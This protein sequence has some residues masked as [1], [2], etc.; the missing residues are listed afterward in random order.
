MKKSI[1]GIILVAMVLTILGGCGQSSTP[2]TSQTTAISST[3]A[4]N[5]ASGTSAS[6]STSSSTSADATAATT[7]QTTASTADSSAVTADDQDGD[8]IPDLVEKTYGT[9]P[10]TADTD[11][12]GTNDVNDQTPVYTDNLISETS[13]TVLPIT[14]K[15][16]RVEDNAAADHLEITFKNDGTTTL[17][18]FDI[19]YTITDKVNTDQVEGY[20]QK[21]DGL[22]VAAGE[23]VT[24]H[25]D[26]NVDQANHYY[27]NMNGL[28]GT[29][30]NG[31]TFAISLHAAGYQPVTFTV[32]KADGTAEV[33]D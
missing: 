12:D 13:S 25:F 24:L 9:N 17:S 27:G 3:S 22:S 11:G 28:Y 23:S 8:G 14:I 1:T 7:D 31:L 15:D 4:S 20:Y 10:H 26:N 33:A 18:N 6:S 5:S 30:S 32:D 16:A 29:S 21:L 19:Y 2:S